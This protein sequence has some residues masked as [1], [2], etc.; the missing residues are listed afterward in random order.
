MAYGPW[1]HATAHLHAAFTAE[2]LIPPFGPL[3][4]WPH[5]FSWDC[6]L[7]PR[8]QKGASHLQCQ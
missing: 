2:L 5:V 8:Q 1:N 6:E 4:D 7:T 3:P